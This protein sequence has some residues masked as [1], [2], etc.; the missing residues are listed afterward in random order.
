MQQQLCTARYHKIGTQF[1]NAIQNKL[2]RLHLIYQT[3]LVRVDDP[4][5]LANLESIETGKIFRNKYV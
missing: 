5:L 4:D 1:F 2:E 3:I